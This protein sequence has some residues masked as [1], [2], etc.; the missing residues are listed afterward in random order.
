MTRT[1]MLCL[2]ILITLC[3][4]VVL[5]VMIWFAL[6]KNVAR[7]RSVA[8]AMDCAGNAALNGDYRETISSRAG[9]RWPRMA[10]FVNWLFAD[11]SHCSDA[12]RFTQLET[13]RGI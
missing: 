6:R 3:V 9:R 12:V 11:P 4:P 13:T 10:R 2:S 7:F 1:Q 5:A 8:L